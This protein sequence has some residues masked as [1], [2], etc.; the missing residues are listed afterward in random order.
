MTITENSFKERFHNHTKSFIHE[1]YPDEKEL[2]KEYWEIKISNFIP[3]GTC[4]ILGEWSANNFS[5][6]QCYL[7]P[8]E[9]LETKLI[10]AKQS[11]T[12]RFDQQ[13]QNT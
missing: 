9:K 4:S 12:I 3:K 13:V 10:A 5:K 1:D 11:T 6:R 8:N 2:L 7:C